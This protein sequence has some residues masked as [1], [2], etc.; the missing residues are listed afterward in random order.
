MISIIIT[1]QKFTF[2]PTAIRSNLSVL[3]T[4]KLNRN[5]LEQIDKQVIFSDTPF[6]DV[7]SFVWKVD[8]NAFLVYRIDTDTYF[9]NFDKLII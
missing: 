7:T 3:I 8:K 5:D 9:K 2:V 1:S 6:W 4:F